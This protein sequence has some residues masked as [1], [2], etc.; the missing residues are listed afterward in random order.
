MEEGN[1]IEIEKQ[2]SR[3]GV[4]DIGSKDDGAILEMV[5]INDRLIIVK[6]RSLYEFTLADTLD[7]KREMPNLPPHVHK[8]LLKQGANDPLVA[9]TF[10]TAKVLFMGGHYPDFLNVRN[11]LLQML[12]VAKELIEMEEAIK[13]YLEE[14]E[15]SIQLW[16]G[17]KGVPGF[18][19][20]SI[21]NLQTRCKTIFQ[22]ADHASQGFMD[23]IRT[24]F[25][26]FTQGYYSSFLTFA[27]DK[28]GDDDSFVSYLRQVTP[29]MVDVRN[30]RNCLDHR[31]VELQIRDFEFQQD[32][33]I[34]APTIEMDDNGSKILRQDLAAFLP[35][36]MDSLV[37]VIEMMLAFLSSRLLEP[38]GLSWQVREVPEDK[39]RYKLVN[40]GLWS[41]IG[42]DGFYQQ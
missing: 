32:G 27:N 37:G 19:L 38:W 3:G 30:I 13:E 33:Q 41:P 20:P 31:K 8:L 9:R 11:G 22:K 10:L 15:R 23:V 17:R 24:F 42:E 16:R 18:M 4:A 26:D 35:G 25:P 7:P 5:N 2:R 34:L 36:V 28:Y 21:P 1:A 6:E 40:F 39:R 29:F 12:E 14:Q